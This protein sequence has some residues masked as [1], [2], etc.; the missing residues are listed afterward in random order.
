MRRLATFACRVAI[1]NLRELSH[2]YRLT[3]AVTN[4]CQ[5]RCVMCGIWSKEPSDELSLAEIDAF[6]ARN[7]RFSWINLTGGELFLRDDFAGIVRSIDSRCR[8]LFLLNFPTNGWETDHIVATVRDILTHMSVPRLMVTVSLDG[9]RELHDRI[10]GL[11]G[12]YERALAT[13]RRLRDLRSRRF[14]VYLGYTLQDANLDAFHDTVMAVRSDLGALEENEIHVNL[15][16]VSAHYYANSEFGG[17]AA[18]Q[19]A[20]EMLAAIEAKRTRG[21]APVS[22][23]ERTY[24]RLARVYLTTGRSPVPCQ[25]AAASCFLDPA[26]T[27]YPCTSFDAPLGSIRDHDYDLSRLWQRAERQTVRRAV[28]S[29]ACPGCW[30]PCEAYQSILANLLRKSTHV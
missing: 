6:F 1:S 15:A 25:A 28:C 5:A 2:P 17:I 14:S 29:A 30:T 16:H 24:Q 21:I 20:A 7:N 10:R 9:P 26:G 13:F 27:V 19:D 18:R 12:S 23:L 11:S 3:Y 22:F 8:S 4:R